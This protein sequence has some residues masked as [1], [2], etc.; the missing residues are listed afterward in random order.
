MVQDSF[1]SSSGFLEHPNGFKNPL[2]ELDYVKRFSNG[3]GK[4]GVFR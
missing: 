3:K 1:V 2:T 4:T